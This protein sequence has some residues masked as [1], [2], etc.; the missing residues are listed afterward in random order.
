MAGASRF[1]NGMMVMGLFSCLLLCLLCYCAMLDFCTDSAGSLCN[2][3]ASGLLRH[4]RKNGHLSSVAVKRGP[5]I[6]NEMPKHFGF[7]FTL[8]EI[9]KDMSIIH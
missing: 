9:F 1:R 6:V 8:N 5:K 2:C 4:A 3:S 7:G